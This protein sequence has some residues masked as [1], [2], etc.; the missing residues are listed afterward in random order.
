MYIRSWRWILAKFKDEPL[1]Q[2]TKTWLKRNG[3]AYRKFIFER[4]NDCSSDPGGN[5]NNRFYI[6][7]KNRIRFFIEDDFEKAIKLSH[8]CDVVF[9]LSHPYNEPQPQQILPEEISRLRKNLP[10][11]IIRV[12]DWDEISR[13]MR[14]LS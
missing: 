11:N 6:S 9:L 10:A 13:Q 3:F 1:K 14:L 7:R 4:G 5:F 2:I 12:K 8:I